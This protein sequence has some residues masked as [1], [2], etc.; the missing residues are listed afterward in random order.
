MLKK[1]ITIILLVFGFFASQAQY[2]FQQIYKDTLP[3][4]P[5]NIIETSNGDFIFSIINA[6]HTWISKIIKMDKEGNIIDSIVIS[7]ISNLL[8]SLFKFDENCFFACGEWNIDNKYSFWLRKYDY[9]LQLLN[10]LSIPIS[11]HSNGIHNPIIINNKNN[12]VVSITCQAS[13][14]TSEVHLFEINLNCEIIKHKIYSSFRGSYTTDIIEKD[15]LYYLFSMA[16]LTKLPCAMY[17]LDSAF[18]ILKLE[19]SGLIG[20][21][22][23]AKWINDSVILLSERI[24]NDITQF[25]ETKVLKIKV[26]TCLNWHYPLKDTVFAKNDSNN[27]IAWKNNLDFVDVN[28]IFLGSFVTK[29]YF[30]GYL[31]NDYSHLVLYKLDSALHVKWEKEYGGDAYYMLLSITATQDGG[32]IMTGTRYDYLTQNNE[33]DPFVIKVNSEGNINWVHNLPST[34]MKVSVYPNPGCDK[35][36][37]NNPPLNTSL[38]LYNTYGQAVITQSLNQS[39]SINTN[40]LQSGVYLYQLIDDKGKVLGA[41]KWV[42]GK[43]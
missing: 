5:G 14:T 19:I 36:T 20:D 43:K 2:T 25:Q 28:N 16:R 39:N 32:C 6:Y 3:Q 1:T 24:H 38:V 13:Q 11:G 7:N 15:S 34:F 42:K 26:D 17:K 4:I 33:T 29:E 22:N 31:S 9:N 37:V 21:L 30:G 27:F 40:S 41:G 35:L 12:L 8:N 10:E 23:N 18:N